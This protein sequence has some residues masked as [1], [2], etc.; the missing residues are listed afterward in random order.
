M[1]L[2]KDSGEIEILTDYENRKT[3]RLKELIPDWW[4]LDK[5]FSNISVGG[6]I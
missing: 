5:K 4:G 3:V 6:K 2:S 1:Q